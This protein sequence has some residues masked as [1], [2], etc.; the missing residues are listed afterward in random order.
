MNESTR[1]LKVLSKKLGNCIE[2]ARPYYDAL[3]KAREAQIECQ[4]A[5]V[6]FQRANGKYYCMPF[7]SF[8]IIMI[9][10]KCMYVT[11]KKKYKKKILINFLFVFLK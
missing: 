7:F 6:K 1:R 5:A 8:K 11:A 9:F 3:E 2:K 4:K 10:I